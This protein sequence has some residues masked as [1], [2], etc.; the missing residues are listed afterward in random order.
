MHSSC[1]Q[2]QDGLQ[3]TTTNYGSIYTQIHKNYICSGARSNVKQ[4]CR[5]QCTLSSSP[6]SYALTLSFR[7]IDYDLN[8]NLYN[9][10]RSDNGSTVIK[11]RLNVMKSHNHY[12]RM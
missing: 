5:I 11:K 6:F 3:A 1:V 12:D 9:N 4:Y 2:M 7:K 10:S 8:F